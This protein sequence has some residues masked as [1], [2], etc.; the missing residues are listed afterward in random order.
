[1]QYKD[2]NKEVRM[3]IN[4][5]Y[6]E[7]MILHLQDFINQTMR[8]NNKKANTKKTQ[9]DDCNLSKNLQKGYNHE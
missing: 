4:S 1:M 8:Q 5:L 2:S 3:N 6:L 7:A 9:Q